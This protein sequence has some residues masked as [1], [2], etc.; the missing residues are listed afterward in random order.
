M[1]DLE[2]TTAA[3]PSQDSLDYVYFAVGF[4]VIPFY[5][6]FVLT[7]L[8]NRRHEPYN[9]VFYQLCI[10]LG[11]SDCLWMLTEPTRHV[12][13]VRHK[14]DVRPTLESLDQ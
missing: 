7:I 8:L 6:L 4:F 11:L 10:V 13:H 5:A 14:V 12:L 1:D 9:S 2:R 3:P